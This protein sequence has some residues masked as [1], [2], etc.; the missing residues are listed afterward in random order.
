MPHT[1]E[2]SILEKVEVD[3]KI[4]PI[5][6]PINLDELKVAYETKYCL[7]MKYG[8]LD[9]YIDE[10]NEEKDAELEKWD[11]LLHDQ[12]R[13]IQSYLD[14]LGDFDNVHLVNNIAY[15]AKKHSMRIGD[16]ENAVGVSAGYISRT[17]KDKTKKKLS[18]DIVWKIA[19]LFEVDLEDLL[20]SDLSEAPSNTNLIIKFLDKLQSKTKKNQLN[21]D[22]NGGYAAYI[23]ERFTKTGLV[24]EAELDSPDD[25]GDS[26]HP[27]HLNPEMKWFLNNEIYSCKDIVKGKD[28]AI[29]KFK[30]IEMEQVLYDFIFIDSIDLTKGTKQKNYKWEKA[31][32]SAD[33]RFGQIQEYASKLYDA[34]ECQAD[35]A[36][37]SQST[38]I[39]IGE[40]LK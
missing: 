16:V 1:F 22:C 18:V 9:H 14:S 13:M 34:I 12:G 2:D 35:D 8:S 11:S 4:V 21:W 23:D 31:F 27:E 25:C 3:G 38:R 10:E 6:T 26:Y 19:K 32:Y 29:I 5:I 39:I 37:L 7:Q 30:C 40:F 33:D 28:F 15:L 17:V 24:T 20:E 36:E